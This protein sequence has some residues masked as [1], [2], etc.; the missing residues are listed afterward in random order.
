MP[1][2]IL[3]TF[4]GSNAPVGP[5]TGFGGNLTFPAKYNDLT[6]S[7]SLRS[8]DDTA[9]VQ[10][11]TGNDLSVSGSLRSPNDITLEPIQSTDLSTSSSLRTFDDI[12]QPLNNGGSNITGS[13]NIGDI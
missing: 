13:P 9:Q 12:S 1:V 2:I 8:P 7:G 11:I 3:P 5:P 6:V 4:K 10:P